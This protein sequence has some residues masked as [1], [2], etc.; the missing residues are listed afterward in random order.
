[1]SWWLTFHL[2]G[3]ILWTGGLLA[4]SRV[5]AYHV[6]EAPAVQPRFAWV[7]GRMYWLV[8]I[9]GTVIALITAAGLLS[10]GPL[11]YMTLGW[12][13]AK[14]GLVILLALLHGFLHLK[15]RALREHPEKAS[16]ALFSAVHGTIGLTL[17]AILIMVEVRPF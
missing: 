10:A 5:A 12:F 11:P 16:K 9:P 14:M 4:V 17:I 8:T 2:L 6:V 7:E 1:M 15:L 13:R 3:V